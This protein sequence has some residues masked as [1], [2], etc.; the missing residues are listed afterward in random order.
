[1]TLSFSD[2]FDLQI[3]F[4]SVR[5]L[6]EKRNGNFQQF[7]FS[8]FSPEPFCYSNESVLIVAVAFPLSANVTLYSLSVYALH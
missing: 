2:D 5:N 6:K 1:M 4:R 7:N 3:S 8:F